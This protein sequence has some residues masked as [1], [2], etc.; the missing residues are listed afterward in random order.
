MCGYLGANCGYYEAK[1]LRLVTKTGV[2]LCYNKGVKKATYYNFLHI[3]KKVMTNQASTTEQNEQIQISNFSEHVRGLSGIYEKKDFLMGFTI[4]SQDSRFIS[5]KS[6]NE[7]LIDI[8]IKEGATDLRTFKAWT[9]AGYKVR[10]GA[11]ALILWSA[12][13][14]PKNDK[15]EQTEQ[16]P[17][18]DGEK[19]K[20]SKFFGVAHVFDIVDVEKSV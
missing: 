19:N 9:D 14:K 17:D 11:K 20:Y 3:K 2:T 5:D 7:A 6:V 18:G 4:A 12:P 13:I 10:K 15:T 1:K 16:K 8:Y